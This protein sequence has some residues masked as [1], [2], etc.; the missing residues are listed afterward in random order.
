MTVRIEFGY[1]LGV[2]A[3]WCAKKTTV[4]S[5]MLCGKRKGWMPPVQQP[6]TP[7]NLCPDCARL[8]AAGQELQPAVDEDA[9]GT[10]P[11][12]V[13]R[14]PLDGA[15]MV[16]E[17]GEWSYRGGRLVVTDRPCAGRGEPPEA[18]S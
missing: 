8:L 5:R 17:H 10:C 18:E 9:E 14:V 3:F 12:C 13:G 1:A 7:P 11:V 4:Q 16:A 6:F 2:Q 15:G